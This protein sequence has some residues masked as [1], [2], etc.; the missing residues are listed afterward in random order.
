MARRSHPFIDIRRGFRLARFLHQLIALRPLRQLLR[1]L[2]RLGCGPS[3]PFIEGQGML[4]PMP[5]DS[6]EPLLADE[7]PKPRAL[8]FIGR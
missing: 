3:Q 7:F 1:F 8:G 6:H 2:A 4:A 5:R